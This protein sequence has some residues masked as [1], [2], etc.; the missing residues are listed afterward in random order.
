M[1][2]IHRLGQSRLG[3]A[4]LDQLGAAAL[5]ALPESHIEWT[6]D[7]YLARIE[8]VVQKIK[9]NPSIRYV[10]PEGAFYM[11]LEIPVRDAEA[12]ALWL[13][14]SFSHQGQRLLVTPGKDFYVD[15]TRGKQ[16]IRIAFVLEPKGMATAM[17]I[18]LAGLKAY[19]ALHP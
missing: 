16:E 5:Y 7:Q 17:D 15:A 6:R 14:Q 10:R 4:L 18:L 12:F 8:T 9:T 2:R 3:V 11:M 1:Q 19:Q 13:I